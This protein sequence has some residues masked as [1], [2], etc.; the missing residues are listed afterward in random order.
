MVGFSN[1]MGNILNFIKK[2]AIFIIVALFVIGLFLVFRISKPEDQSQ[3][4][5]KQAEF[6][7]L[8]PGKSTKKKVE[9][10]LGN[11]ITTE[12]KEEQEI[13]EYKSSSEVNKHRVIYKDGKAIFINETVTIEDKKNFQPIID[14]FGPAPHIL[15]KGSMAVA[16]FGLYVYPENGIAYIGNPAGDG[17]ILEIWYFEPTTI[18]EFKSTWATGYSERR[19]LTQ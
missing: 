5:Q 10:E 1:K 17:V 13:S 16:G 18:N 2:K 8:K 15:Y 14:E 3:F 9:E 6:N 19:T 11:P 12:Q 7:D 4:S